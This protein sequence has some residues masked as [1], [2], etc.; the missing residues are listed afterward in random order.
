M[1]NKNDI[2]GLSDCK[3]IK[4]TL[5]KQINGQI[6]INGQDGTHFSIKLHER[7]PRWEND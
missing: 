5:T 3:E 4:N 7:T 2:K 6:E 1:L